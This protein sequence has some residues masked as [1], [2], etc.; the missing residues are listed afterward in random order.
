MF[1]FSSLLFLYHDS[2]TT[3][4]F[5]TLTDVPFGSRYLC[6]C[7]DAMYALECIADDSYSVPLNTTA[8]VCPST[9]FNDQSSESFL[10][11]VSMDSHGF[12]DMPNYGVGIVGG[13]CRRTS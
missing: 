8:S 9:P 3:P 7:T 12:L 11:I 5:T 1:Y 2:A 13:S 4:T 6:D 10:L